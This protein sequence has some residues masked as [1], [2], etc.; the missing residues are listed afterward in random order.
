LSLPSPFLLTLSS[1]LF[2]AP[3]FCI[4]AHAGTITPQTIDV[5]TFTNAQI[6]NDLTTA[7]GTVTGTL[8]INVTTGHMAMFTYNLG[9]NPSSFYIDTPSAANLFLGL[10]DIRTFLI[11]LIT[12]LT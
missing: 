1:L 3:A 12:Q 11:C 10:V 9:G 4:A 2:L 5:F 7:E 6:Y 8:S